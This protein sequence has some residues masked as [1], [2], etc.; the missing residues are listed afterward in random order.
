MVLTTLVFGGSIKA[1]AMPAGLIDPK[2]ETKVPHYFGP[3]PNWALSPLREARAVVDITGG[4]GNGATATATVDPQ[5]GAI[6][7]I[8]I[9]NPGSG[10]TSAPLVDITGLGN[11]AQATAVVDYSGNSVV[12]QVTVDVAGSGYT[13]PAV[14]I[15]G[16]GSL[17]TNV[18][19]GNSL[20]PRQNAT[21]YA[22]APGVWPRIRCPADDDACLEPGYLDPV[23]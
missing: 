7:A 18:T 5:T 15:S 21:D 22:V 12:N 13:A 14:T 8:T 17:G 20:S 9:T 23:L 6:T 1:T 16:G 2:D 3:N 11:G 10:Y 4:G 19:V